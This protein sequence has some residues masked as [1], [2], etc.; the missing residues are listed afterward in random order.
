M[1]DQLERWV[2]IEALREHSN[3]KTAAA[4]ALGISREGLHKKVRAFGL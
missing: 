2:L 3:N 1:M 4:K